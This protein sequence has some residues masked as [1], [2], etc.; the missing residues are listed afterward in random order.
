[1]GPA[2]GVRGRFGQ[3]RQPLGLGEVPG[4]RTGPVP[5][6]DDAAPQHIGGPLRGLPRGSV[7]RGRPLV[8]RGPTL[9][10]GLVLEFWPVL[11]LRPP[12][13]GHRVRRAR[14]RG[15][16]GV[17]HDGLE[18][19]VRQRGGGLG[20][21][22]GHA[23]GPGAQDL[24]HA[25]VRV[26]GLVEGAVDLH[27][28]ARPQGGLG[29]VLGVATGQ[30]GEGVG[31]SGGL[32]AGG[33]LGVVGEVHADPH[34]GAEDAGLVRGLV[35]AGAAQPRGPVRAEHGQG[36]LG[37]VGF[38][39]GRQQLPD[40]GAGGG[41]HRRRRAGGLGQAQGGEAGGA[42]VDAH[43]HLQRPGVGGG[44]Q[45]VGQGRGPGAGGDH[46][47]P[48]PR[49]DQ[50]VQDGDGGEERVGTLIGGGLGFRG[51]PRQF[52]RAR[53]PPDD[54]HH[55]PPGIDLFRR[56]S[57]AP[58]SHRRRPADVGCLDAAPQIRGLRP[59]EISAGSAGCTL[60]TA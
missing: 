53:T 1:M 47:V 33:L 15:A 43:V 48:H 7:P 31:E 29:P 10:P 9:G 59:L 52:T 27:G 34:V 8:C 19:R 40:R 50:R 57:I 55:P 39:D 26:Q 45:R 32:R 23:V 5:G 42:L 58:S 18:G 46:R 30:G 38:H 20:L 16:R 49:A 35:G 25:P 37:V 60:R 6:D 54:A 22:A 13:G 36:D 3:Q 11:G 41:H 21:E 2:S 28:A 12:T 44:R 4:Q 56:P 24:A 14:S 51:H 17:G